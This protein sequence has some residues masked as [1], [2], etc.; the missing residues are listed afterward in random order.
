MPAFVPQVLYVEDQP[1]N[2]MLMSALFERIPGCR[3]QLAACGRDALAIART[4]RPALL[5]LDLRLPDM[6]GAEL[7]ARLRLV[8]GCEF[9]PAVAVTAE[10]DFDHIAAGF[11]ELWRKPLALLD[12]VGRVEALV[13]LP[14]HPTLQLDTPALMAQ[15]AAGL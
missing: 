6:N 9:A 15:Y 7:L 8:P 14:R 4:L 10:H 13:A 5:L 11:D 2:A 1:V 12:V 3:L